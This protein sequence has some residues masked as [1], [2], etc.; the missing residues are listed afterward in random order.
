MPAE[1]AVRAGR[2]PTIGCFYEL[3]LHLIS[4]KPI[5]SRMVTRAVRGVVRHGDDQ[6]RIG[7]TSVSAYRCNMIRI[8]RQIGGEART[9][10]ICLSV[11]NAGCPRVLPSAD[12][13]APAVPVP[14]PH[15]EGQQ[16]HGQTSEHGAGTGGTIPSLE[17]CLAGAAWN[18]LPRRPTLPGCRVLSLLARGVMLAG[19]FP[20]R[21]PEAWP[22]WSRMPA[23][24][25]M[26]EL[27]S[28]EYLMRRF[29]HCHQS[30]SSAR[31]PSIQAL[32]L[33]FAKRYEQDA[34]SS[35]PRHPN[36]TGAT[37]RTRAQLHMNRAV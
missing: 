24:V 17:R 9:S 3:P 16:H 14:A 33:N 12:A 31:D 10:V 32:H 7:M 22:R 5:R 8:Y 18:S 21:S 4:V 1:P 19:T 11:S 30:A 34:Q 37:N 20:P 36:T 15:G 23:E 26:P 27:H 13:D 28:R 6:C 29:Q 2:P 35:G 25:E